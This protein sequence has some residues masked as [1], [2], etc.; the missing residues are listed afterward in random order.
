MSFEEKDFEL[1]Y[2]KLSQK[3]EEK[4]KYKIDMEACKFMRYIVFISLFVNALI[5]GLYVLVF[6][7]SQNHALIT[8]WYFALIFMNIVNVLWARL[9]SHD[10]LSQKAI[11]LSWQGYVV[12]I[13]SICLIW[14]SIGVLFVSNDLHQELF[15]IS[16]LAAAVIAFTYPTSVDLKLGFLSIL[17]LLGPIIVAR[18][19]L[20]I[21]AYV[22]GNSI[23]QLNFSIASTLF[24][25][26]LFMLIS[27]YMANKMI[28]KV[29]HLGFENDL[30]RQ[31]L[32]G[33]NAS[34]EH[35]V[36]ERTE[37]LEKSLKLVSYQA[38]HDLLTELPNERL[39]NEKM[40][41]FIEKAVTNHY[42]FAVASLSL[43]NMRTISDSI[44][45]NAS[46]K[47]LHR[48]AQ[49]F[50]DHFKSNHQLSFYLSRQ[51]V[52]IILINPV[53]NEDEIRHYVKE[54][55]SVLDEPVYVANQ[56]IKLTGS[57]GVC[58]F[59]DHGREIDDLL[60]NAHAARLQ[61][62]E[63]GGNNLRIYSQVI[64]ADASRLLKMENLLYSVVENQELFIEY[65]P[66]YNLKDK[67]ICGAEAL[68][69]WNSPELGVVS[70]LSF[71]SVAEAN[72]MI[73]PIGEW[74]LRHGLSELKNWHDLGYDD[75]RLAINL[76]AKQ[77]AD[78][79]LIDF[80]K[81]ILT[82]KGLSPKSL[83]LELTESNVFHREVLPLVNQFVE[84]GISLSIDDFGTGYSEF[85]NLKLFKVNLIKID[86]S[87][88]DDIDVN[89][90]SQNIVRN[91]IS[92]ARSMGIQC[93]A[94]GVETQE[95]VD[96]LMKNGCY[97]IQGFY[98]SPPVNEK[99]FTRLLKKYPLKKRNGKKPG[100]FDNLS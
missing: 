94:E 44:G 95:Q 76:S 37:A 9:S 74:V 51:D 97:I 61:A 7:E 78:P 30:L 79:A 88:I 5:G 23:F 84:M 33:T 15:T 13:L 82:E 85:S 6:Y 80:V 28:L 29:L 1:S 60:T 20:G 81:K 43:N 98:F 12:I 41:S 52:F 90:D 63:Q 92:L 34:L 59:P 47:I 24:I 49:R 27:S 45:F 21:E 91:T 86:K 89:I 99:K 31:K 2:P 57:V 62:S 96:F 65:Q 100:T 22:Q 18:Y 66:F 38:S 72:G 10:T 16:V 35:R 40:L 25:L 73:I 17:F 70:P 36:Q 68:V 56:S 48:I 93:M 69:R 87:F 14:G 54:L 11:R 46:S 42:R 4:V 75:L 19:Y 58:V 55:L 71:I 32:E 39:L 83:E 67:G 50:L 8:S 77:L 64:N 53:F 3:E 26:A